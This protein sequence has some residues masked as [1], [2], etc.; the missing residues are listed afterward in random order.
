MRPNVASASSEA[1]NTRPAAHLEHDVDRLAAVGLEQPLGQP[2]GVA[3]ERGVGAELEREGALV[4]AG[5]QRDD[6]AR[7]ERPSKLHA[8]RP[9]P[10]RGPDDHDRLAL[11]Q[12]GRR[13]QQ[14]P[15]RRALDEH[16]ERGALVEALGQRHAD[17]LV[18]GR[19]LRVAARPPVSATTR[20]PVSS[21]TP[22]TSLPGTNGRSALCT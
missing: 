19:D 13:P 17:R 6:A 5:G 8:Q 1:S 2:L 22:A 9:R 11:G 15:R 16:R 7:A 20:S 12:V 3:V 18:D 4:R 14:M 10:T 21:R